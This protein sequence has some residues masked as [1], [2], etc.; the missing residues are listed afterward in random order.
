MVY[1]SH[2][3]QNFML[4]ILPAVAYFVSEVCTRG[5]I[6]KMIHFGLCHSVS[7]FLNE[8][9]LIFSMHQWKPKALE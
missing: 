6:K 2:L 4:T 5:H 3:Q 8:S 7:L 1:S 9:E